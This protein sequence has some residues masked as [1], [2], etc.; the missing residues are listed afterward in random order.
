[1]QLLL[2]LYEEIWTEIMLTDIHPFRYRPTMSPIKVRYLLPKC[3]VLDSK[4]SPSFCHC[5]A[6][7]WGTA[8]E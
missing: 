3:Q 2:V 4:D 7:N 5:I 1:M 6:R 8:Q